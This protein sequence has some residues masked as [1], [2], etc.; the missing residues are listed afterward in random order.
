[1]TETSV[2]KPGDPVPPTTFPTAGGGTVSLQDLADRKIVLFAYG[3]DGTPAC[4]SEVLEFQAL[5]PEFE[6]LGA[7]VIGLS[8]DPVKSHDKFA[9]KQGITLILASDH[10]GTEMERWG[11]HGRKLFFGKE[12][13]GVLRKTFLLAG[14]KV[15]RVWQVDRVKG[16]AAEVLQALRA[17]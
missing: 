17:P 11:A 12:V 3:K 1:M 9:A 7:V 10:G 15:E 4:T 2:I 5:K 6:A 14:G 16:H 13:T 8:K